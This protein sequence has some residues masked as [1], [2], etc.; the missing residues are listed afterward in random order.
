MSMLTP[1][2]MGGKY[3]ITGDTYP[4][5]RQS[6]RRGRLVL[7]LVA[8]VAVLGLIGWGTLQLIDVFTGGHKKTAASGSGADCR[9]KAAPSAE[10]AVALPEPKKITVNVYNA[11]KRTGLAKSTADELKKRGFK[12]GKVGNATPEFDKKVK[13]AGILVGPDAALKT[14]L[15]VLGTQ[16]ASAERRAEVARKGTD[17]DFVIGDGFKALTKKADADKAL[18]ALTAPRPASAVSKKD[19]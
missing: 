3:R 2:G 11:T 5:M 7:G 4:R 10:P 12:I 1:P 16:L 8:S 19:C 15:P 6:R 9:T 13:G 14:S 18:A 17:L